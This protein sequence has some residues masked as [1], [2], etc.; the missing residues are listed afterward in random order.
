MSTD[1]YAPSVNFAMGRAE[2][3]QPAYTRLT[4]SAF[5]THL[6]NEIRRVLNERGLSVREVSAAT[7]VSNSSLNEFLNGD[8]GMLLDNVGLVMDWLR[9]EGFAPTLPALPEGIRADDAPA[10]HADV[11]AMIAAAMRPFTKPTGPK[12][13]RPLHRNKRSA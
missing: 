7:G 2:C 8:K 4:M 1:I 9:T 13:Q 11:A 3:S 5:V 10:S 12:V 6:R